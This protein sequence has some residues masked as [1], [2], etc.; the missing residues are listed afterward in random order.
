MST[1]TTEA[2]LQE[3]LGVAVEHQFHCLTSK[4]PHTI[5]NAQDLIPYTYVN[6]NARYAGQDLYLSLYYN[7]RTHII[8]QLKVS[9]FFL[10]VIFDQAGPLLP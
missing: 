4:N 3:G 9:H 10:L 7:Y 8:T 1:W 6:L 2:A 5:Y